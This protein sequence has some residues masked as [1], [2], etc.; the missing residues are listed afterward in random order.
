MLK[1]DTHSIM[2]SRHVRLFEHVFPYHEQQSKSSTVSHNITHANLYT[3][4]HW[5]KSTNS[6]SSSEINSPVL[7]STLSTP[8]STSSISQNDQLGEIQ[9]SAAPTSSPT[10][11]SD[12]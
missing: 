6:N 12:L 5:L 10:S 1:L 7:N 9:S 2:V 3:F 11:D 4:I 8:A